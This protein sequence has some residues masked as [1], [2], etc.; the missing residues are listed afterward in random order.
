VDKP[1]PKPGPWVTKALLCEAVDASGSAYTGCFT[2]LPAA[3]PG[4]SPEAVAV[5]VFEL[6]TWGH[7]GRHTFEVIR[8]DSPREFVS[9][10]RQE[11]DYPE[12]ELYVEI[13]IDVPIPRE[14]P[15]LAQFIAGIDGEIL[16]K[17]P[18]KIVPPVR[19]SVG[20]TGLQA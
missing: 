19:L 14:R 7:R 16:A 13:T 17:V 9:L 11:I 4:E 1:G 10:H 12:D 15:G 18:V 3:L 20:S 8:Q 5:F 2:V 6:M